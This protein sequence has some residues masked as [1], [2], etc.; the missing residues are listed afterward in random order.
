MRVGEI[1]LALAGGLLLLSFFRSR[2]RTAAALRSTGKI[3]L[4]VL[5]V[6]FFIFVLMGALQAFVPRETI[7][8]LLGAGKGPSGVL[9][10]EAVGCF[11]LIQ[12]AAVF[13]FSG[14]LLQSGAGYAAI[15]GF[16]L[17]AIL[18]GIS[19]LPLEAKLFGIRFTF[20]RNLLTF[21]VVFLLAM[22]IGGIL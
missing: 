7:A 18:I 3:A 19:T 10:A 12:P 4:Q 9:L 5:P 13:P 15:A 11:A 14:Y 22:A 8:G 1:Y 20:F 21:L 2:E 6:L 16:V 17:T